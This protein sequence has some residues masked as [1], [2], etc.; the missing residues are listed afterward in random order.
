MA[1]YG[2][3]REAVRVKVK[4]CIINRFMICLDK[5]I[6]FFQKCEA[7]LAP[8]WRKFS[9]DPQITSLEVLYSILAKAFDLKTDFGISY[10]TLDVLNKEIYL[11]VLSDWDLE[12]SFLR[13]HNQSITSGSEPCLNLRVDIKPFAEASDWDSTS[14]NSIRETSSAIQQMTGAGQ[15]YVQNVQNRLPGLIINHME[16]TFSSF[17]QRAMNLVEDP[18][19]DQP[20]RP[21]LSDIEFRSCFLDS[22]GQIMHTNELRKV[23]YTGGIDPSLRYVF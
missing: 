17:V 2:Y 3:S 19:I 20:P 18:T 12:A 22:V 10:K 21:P 13:A 8:E 23:I 7:C 15:R 9:V 1:G 4:V 5:Q 14:N 11:P 6:F 16:K